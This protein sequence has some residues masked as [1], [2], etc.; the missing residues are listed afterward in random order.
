[1]TGNLK[2][3]ILRNKL[4]IQNYSYLSALRIFNFLVPIITLPYLLDVLGKDNYGLVVFSQTIISY[5]SIFIN[6]GFNLSATKEISKNRN[7]LLKISEIVSS[8]FIIKGILFLFS[9]FILY[10][11]TLF[12]QDS[13]LVTLM[14]LM[15][16]L[17]F[18][19]W[20]FPIW[21]FQGL[22]KMKYIAIINV[23]RGVVFLIFIFVFITQK[24]HFFRVPVING[25][26]FLISGVVAFW[27]VFY[28]DKIKF[29]FQTKKTL[30]YYF[31]DSFPLF[32]GNIA[33]QIKMLSN[34]AF[35]GVFVGM[36]SVAVYDVAD[37][38]KNV[39]LSFLQ[40]LVTVLFPNLAN[41]AD[42][43]L[44]RRSIRL[45]FFVGIGTYLIIVF[46]SAVVIPIYFMEYIEV[47]YL[48]LLLGS[49]I[50]I[51][52]VSYLIGIGVLLVNDLKK[53]YTMTLYISASVYLGLILFFYIFKHVSIYTLSISLVFSALVSIFV[54]IRVAKNNGKI[55]WIL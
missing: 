52:P 35:I 47:F 34:K 18:Y 29:K 3:V 11:I 24:D 2:K 38:I 48:L 22:E 50:F 36:E 33:G 19:E 6:F 43:R 8:V 51:Q 37:K 53:N 14:I 45:L 17:C 9:C 23:L 4:M 55:N 46:I 39:F 16:Y 5:F 13:N 21:Y 49:L 12:V 25:I 15:M 42:G 54:N 27:V 28:K 1:M 10:I 26:G 40:L 30:L 41:K 32:I 44:V 7:D 20:V 31:H